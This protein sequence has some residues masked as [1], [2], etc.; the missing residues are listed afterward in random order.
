MNITDPTRWTF[1]EELFHKVIDLPENLQADRVRQMQKEYPEYADAVDKL[2]KA[3]RKSGNFLSGTIVDKIN[4]QPGERVGPWEI[5]REIGRGGMSTVFLAERVDGRFERQVAIKFLHG[6][7]PGKDMADRMKAEQ[8]ILAGLDHK[9]ICKLLDAGVAAGGRPYFIMEYVNGEPVDQYCETKDLTVAQR[10]YLFEQVC[11]AVLYAHQRMIVHRDLKPSNILVNQSGQVKLLDFGIAKILSEEPELDITNTHTSLHLMTPEYASPEQVEYR[12]VTTGTDVYSLSLVL[13]K[14]LTGSLPY[15]L[16]KKTPLEMGKTITDTEPVKPS[17]LVKRLNSKAGERD[18]R[19][20]SPGVER[21]LKGDLDNIILKA[22]RK[23]PDRRYSSVEQFLQ[24]IRNYL[25]DRPVTARPETVGYRAKKFIKRNR[26]PVATAAVVVILL[27]SSMV[28]SLWQAEIADTQRRIAEQRLGDLRELA[29]SMMFEVHDAIAPL[30]GSVEA[31]EMIASTISEYL[32]QISSMNVEDPDLKLELAGSY[33]RIGDLLGNPTTSN[34][35]RSQQALDN[36]DKALDQLNSTPSWRSVE[37]TAFV[38]ERAVILEK[39]SDVLASLQR[40]DEA[41]N[42]QRESVSLFRQIM[43]RDSNDES[44]FSYAVSL[45]K[46]GDLMGHPNFQNLGMP[47]SS[48]TLYKSAESILDRLYQRPEKS[49]RVVRYNGLI[50]ERIGV[51][52]EQLRQTESSIEHFEKSMEMRE[53]FIELDPMN[54]NAI[55]DK[56]V[57]LENLAKVYLTTGNLAEAEKRFEESFQ[58]FK[59]L[60]NSDPTNYSAIQSLAV[61]HIHLGDLAYHPDRPSYNKVD[62]SRG[63]FLESKNL[64]SQL[65]AIEPS[66]SRT[67]FLLDLVEG[68]LSRL[69]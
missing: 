24:D 66:N 60:Y 51:I 53:E 30:P 32:E 44:E 18:G 47:D 2:W 54:Y 15:E 68:R 31:R 35:G 3:H 55:R 5:Q 26:G 16:Q 61:S 48:L 20:N 36:Y 52:Y 56:A 62:E 41:E 11:E 8:S 22:L 4:I 13:C 29:G 37:N 6:F 33:R 43:N 67:Q 12:P 50:H 1:I 38:R 34:L 64:L 17:A 10:L 46:L 42:L 39:K 27:I 40:L 28:I 59:W 25:E 57:S 19:N 23:D 65:I 14:I 9:N 69:P 45:L 63:H 7:I 21:I 49:T 58:T